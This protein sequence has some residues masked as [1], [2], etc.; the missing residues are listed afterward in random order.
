[1][2]QVNLW[3]LLICFTGWY[4][5]TVERDLQR[6][7]LV[8]QSSNYMQSS[9]IK[10]VF[11]DL[12]MTKIHT[13]ASLA[14]LF[15]ERY[16]NAQS[17]LKVRLAAT[18]GSP[19]L[20][21]LAVDA[22]NKQTQSIIDSYNKQEGDLESKHI[23]AFDFEWQLALL[24][25][26]H[27]VVTLAYPSHPIGTVHDAMRAIGIEK[28][29]IPSEY[30]PPHSF[31]FHISLIEFYEAGGGLGNECQERLENLFM[32]NAPEW[33]GGGP[34][35]LVKNEQHTLFKEYLLE[36]ECFFDPPLTVV[37]FSS[38]APTRELCR[39]KSFEELSNGN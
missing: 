28:G 29:I 16:I 8:R 23:W 17:N 7:L 36:Q 35:M 38:W 21:F 24:G 1:M 31:V 2:N 6:P 27:K 34:A 32:E 13:I 20:L 11:D 15:F 18:L 14:K 19:T 30:V 37:G 5:I 25:R 26:Q 33:A 12:S 10:A 3:G 4:G 22:T 9:V 39:V